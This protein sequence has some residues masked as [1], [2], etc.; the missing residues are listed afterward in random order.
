MRKKVEA[1]G[2]SSYLKKI[3]ICAAA[4]IALTIALATLAAY[5]ISSEIVPH[6]MVGLC[7]FVSVACGTALAVFLACG[8]NKKL[9]SCAAVVAAYAVLVLAIGTAMIT[10]PIQSESLVYVLGSAMLG[11]IVG[12]L[13]SAVK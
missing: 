13:A 7:S 9:F 3:G 11:G 8:K 10:A 4:G 12:M 2:H 1:Y 6:G 5:L